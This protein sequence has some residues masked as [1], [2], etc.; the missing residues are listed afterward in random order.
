MEFQSYYKTLGVARDA[1]AEDIE[2]AF[3]KLARKFHLA[4]LV[5]KRV[6]QK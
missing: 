4:L 3:R 6:S 5:R 2:K 1:A